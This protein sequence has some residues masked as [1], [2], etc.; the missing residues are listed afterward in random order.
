MLF[1][2]PPSIHELWDPH[3]SSGKFM[4]LRRERG[5]N[6]LHEFWPFCCKSMHKPLGCGGL[7]RAVV[8]GT[9]GEEVSPRK[10]LCKDW[11]QN[12]G[13]LKG[14]FRG[15]S[16]CFNSERFKEQL[17][18]KNPLDIKPRQKLPHNLAAAAAGASLSVESTRGSAALGAGV[19]AG[20][21]RRH[22]YL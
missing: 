22:C 8:W 21:G 17:G 12:G 4:H 15:G 18:K 9:V 3:H 1:Y 6:L 19:G 13:Q 5:G 14:C 10:K 11:H 16:R 7:N 20:G 2:S